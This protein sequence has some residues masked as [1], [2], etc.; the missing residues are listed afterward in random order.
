MTR[1]RNSGFRITFRD[2]Q[3]VGKTNRVRDVTVASKKTFKTR[4][5]AVTRKRQIDAN[6]RQ[7]GIKKSRAKIVKNT[8]SIKKLQKKSLQKQFF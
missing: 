1:N 5:A 4:K 7:F 6:L 2:L 8:R 3:R